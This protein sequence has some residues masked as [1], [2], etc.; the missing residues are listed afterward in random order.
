MSFAGG[1]SVQWWHTCKGRYREGGAAWLILFPIGLV[2]PLE[3]G[4]AH[5]LAYAILMPAMFLPFSITTGLFQAPVALVKPDIWCEPKQGP[6]FP[7]SPPPPPPPP[8][9]ESDE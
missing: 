1:S 9:A 3:C 2:V 7:L 6:G 5:T 4:G 8:P